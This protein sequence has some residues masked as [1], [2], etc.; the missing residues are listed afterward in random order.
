MFTHVVAY[1]SCRTLEHL[2]ANSSC[3]TL[4]HVCRVCRLIGSR[5]LGAPTSPFQGPSAFYPSLPRSTDLLPLPIQPPNG[6]EPPIRFVREMWTLLRARTAHF[7]HVYVVVCRVNQS[8][9]KVVGVIV[10]PSTFSAPSGLAWQGFSH[11]SAERFVCVS[12]GFPAVFLWCWMRTLCIQYLGRQFMRS[13]ACRCGHWLPGSA[14]L[15][16]SFGFQGR[17]A[18]S[19]RLARWG[20]CARCSRY[21]A[22]CER[23]GR[24]R[25]TAL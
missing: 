12:Y 6:T 18:N 25:K 23:T 21:V 17:I 19:V 16:P 13:F 5:G 8:C 1:S 9:R 15:W 11:F 2:V 10:F 7:L 24:Q 20:I 3:R 14:H 4:E 22:P